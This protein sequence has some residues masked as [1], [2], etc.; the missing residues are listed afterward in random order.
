[1]GRPAFSPTSKHKVRVQ[2]LARK[3]LNEEEISKCLK[4]SYSTFCKYKRYFSEAIKKGR[5]EGDELNVIEV[6]NALKKSAC[7]FEFTETK[8]EYAVCS[9]IDGTPFSSPV[10]LN[11]T[12]TKKFIPPNPASTIFY[13]TN[14]KKDRWTNP[15]KIEPSP[16][17]GDNK[18]PMVS[19]IP[20]IEKPKNEPPNN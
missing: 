1:M 10:L 13:L 20:K 14:R 19:H 9:P 4:I 12:K 11:R 17:G 8:E 18:I 5:E 6:E 15:M 16:G 3:G 7:G 2:E